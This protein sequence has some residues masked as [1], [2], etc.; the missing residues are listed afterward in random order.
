[1]YTK[2]PIFKK[3]MEL[4]VYIET[5]VKSFSRY[6]KYSIGAELREKSREVLYAIYKV[7]FA[8]NKIDA[9]KNLRDTNEE[10]KIIIFLANELKVLKSFKQFEISSKLC[11]EIGKQSQGWLGSSK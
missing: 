11:F 3:A 10:L 5:I 9:I 2:L 1:M 6:H 7:F 8:K 4:N